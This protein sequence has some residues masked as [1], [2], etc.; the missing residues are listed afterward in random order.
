MREQSDGFSQQADDVAAMQLA[1]P[2]MKKYKSLVQ[3]RFDVEALNKQ[4][5]E[6]TLQETNAVL[7]VLLESVTVGTQSG[8]RNALRLL[9]SKSTKTDVDDAIDTLADTHNQT[10]RI[11]KI[12]T[13]LLKNIM[14]DVE[15]KKLEIA[16]LESSVEQYWGF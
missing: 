5:S 14:K 3:D 12:R 8:A 4:R 13:C 10:S 6:A 2:P 11:N 15:V 16:N 9:M 1:P 7:T